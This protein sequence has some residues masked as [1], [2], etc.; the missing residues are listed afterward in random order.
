MGK[1]SEC[2]WPKMAHA[3]TVAA[4]VA[5]LAAAAS[6]FNVDVESNVVHSGPA[7]SGCDGPGSDCMFG[8][9]VAQHRENG[10]AW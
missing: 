6:A 7:G 10:R 2:A 8:F 4:A 3:V 1:V 5:L 9:S